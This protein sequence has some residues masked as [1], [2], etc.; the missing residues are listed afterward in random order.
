MTVTLVHD[1]ARYIC[2]RSRFSHFEQAA[3]L[4][5][6]LSALADAMDSPQIISYNELACLPQVDTVTGQG[7]A[8]VTGSLDGVATLAFV[9]RFHLYQGLTAA[10]VATPVLLAER[11]GVKRVLL[12]N[13]A[14]GINP[15]YAP[16][17]FMLITD[18]LNFT[19]DNPLRGL[20]PPPF[21]DLTTLYQRQFSA[22]LQQYAATAAIRLHEGIYAAVAGP[23]YE[24]P[25]EVRALERLGA[26]AVGMS[27]VAE[28]I[29]AAH[30][31]MGVAGLSLIANRAA[32]LAHQPLSHSEVLAIGR[33][34]ASNFTALCRTL[35]TE[36]SSCH[37]ASA[38]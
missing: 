25:A 12:T 31:G 9:G 11:L 17:D 29:C 18:H 21:V 32:G 28:A 30:C 10:D 14:G 22:S 16:G 36:W 26:D 27:T 37:S 3:V 23:S 6:G 33:D 4:G 24:T 5:S 20:S 2:S 1:A 13:A 8:L 19:G 15:A 7:G 38:R 35:L 34:S